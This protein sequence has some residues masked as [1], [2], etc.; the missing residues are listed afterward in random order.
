[1]SDLGFPSPSDG[2]LG[3]DFKQ[4][5]GE[6]AVNALGDFVADKRYKVVHS[7]NGHTGF[8]KKNVVQRTMASFP[9]R[10][11]DF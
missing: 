7:G 5:C 10:K 8:S 3:V 6:T 2:L 9:S 11:S 1:M 4:N